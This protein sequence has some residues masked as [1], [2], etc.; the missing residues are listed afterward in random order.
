MEHGPLSQRKESPCD[1]GHRMHLL[2]QQEIG[3]Y[4][5]SEVDK[6]SHDVVRKDVRVMRSEIV[7]TAFR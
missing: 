5:P 3:R 6:A 1:S 2:E 7:N 4:R